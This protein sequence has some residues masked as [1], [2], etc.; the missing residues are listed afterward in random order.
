M[1]IRT[2]FALATIAVVAGLSVAS[3]ADAACRL[4]VMH[5]MTVTTQAGHRIPLDVVEYKGHMMTLVPEDMTPDYLHQM[6][7]RRQ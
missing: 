4:H 2:K 7:F 1:T 3:A 5:H 6:I